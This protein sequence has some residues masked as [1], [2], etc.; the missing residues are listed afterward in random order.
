MNTFKKLAVATAL[1]T[2]A[3][4]P[5]LAAEKGDFI[6]RSGFSTIVPNENSTALNLDGIGD[7]GKN[8]DLIRVLSTPGCIDRQMISFP[9]S[10]PVTQ[11]QPGPSQIAEDECAISY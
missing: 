6:V 9:F 5:A 1:S 7:V 8:V 2:T 3:A 4:M 11:W 10:V